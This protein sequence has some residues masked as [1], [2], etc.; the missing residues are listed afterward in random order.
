MHTYAHR[1]GLVAIA[2]RLCMPWAKVRAAALVENVKLD[3]I[4]VETIDVMPKRRHVSDRMQ[5]AH[6]PGL[7]QHRHIWV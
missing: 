3:V 5:K 6:S 1:A 7:E 2:I 4:L